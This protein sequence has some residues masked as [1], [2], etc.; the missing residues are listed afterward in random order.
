VIGA[1]AIPLTPTTVRISES[2]QEIVYIASMNDEN[3][4]RPHELKTFLAQDMHEMASEYERIR[5][6]SVEDPGT[7]GDEGEE[8]WA[9]LL[10]QWL[11]EDYTIVTKGRV[12][13]TDG[14]AGPQVDILILCPG[15]PKRLLNKKLYLAGGVTAVFECKNTL[16]TKHINDTF[17]RAAK[18]NAL[19]NKRNGTPF[20]ELVPAIEFGLLAH[21]HV[22]KASGSQPKQLIDSSLQSGLK[23]LTH[24]SDPP[25]LVCVADLACWTVFRQTYDGP[26]LL[27]P[28]VWKARQALT[29][30]PDQGACS[31]GYYRHTDALPADQA[32]PNAIAPAVTFLLG[33]LARDNV[34]VRPLSQYF[35]AAGM[36]GS[37]TAVA[38]S[39]FPLDVFSD[40]LRAG[41]PRKLINGDAGS[42]WSMVFP[43]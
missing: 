18:V 43:Y 41:L 19:V 42:D 34:P 38:L 2:A 13:G 39:Y 22:W 7:A 12:L 11:P 14:S 37:S 35:H 28:E 30:L 10:R 31:V 8:V 1:A 16:N 3:T 4:E 17:K 5:R 40:E 33:R 9:G 36:S 29:G 21:S 25:G 20:A 6:R 27:P 15:Y 32:P 26:A 24:L 23:R